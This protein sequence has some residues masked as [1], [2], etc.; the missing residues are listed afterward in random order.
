MYLWKYMSRLISILF[1]HNISDW[2]SLERQIVFMVA[3]VVVMWRLNSCS[4]SIHPKQ[5][6]IIRFI[7]LSSRIMSHLS[8]VCLCIGWIVGNAFHPPNP[9][10]NNNKKC[11][12]D[13]WKG[14]RSKFVSTSPAYRSIT[15]YASSSNLLPIYIICRCSHLMTPPNWN[16]KFSAIV[17]GVISIFLFITHQHSL[18]GNALYMEEMS[19]KFHAYS[20]G[21]YLAP[22][23]FLTQFISLMSLHRLFSL[24]CIQLSIG[25]GIGSCKS[26]YS[27]VTVFVFLL[28]T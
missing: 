23:G 27:T 19:F 1:E 24:H 9:I 25:I 13:D 15:K 2:L 3:V 17:V 11:V 28:H 26:N 12:S 5:S 16:S 6:I 4:N 22:N 21:E 10:S 18:A 20:N 7:C 8:Y 14:N